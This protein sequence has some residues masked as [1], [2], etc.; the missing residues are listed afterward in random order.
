MTNLSDFFLLPSKALKWPLMDIALYNPT[1]P[2]YIPSEY[3][4]LGQSMSFLQ[5]VGNTMLR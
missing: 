3:I 5:R 1:N 4:N 2:S